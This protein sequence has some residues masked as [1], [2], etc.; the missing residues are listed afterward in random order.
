MLSLIIALPLNYDFFYY[1]FLGWFWETQTL[2]TNSQENKFSLNKTYY[3]TI[4]RVL[5]HFTHWCPPVQH[6]NLLTFSDLL[7]NTHPY[8][9]TLL[10]PVLK[11]IIQ[12]YIQLIVVNKVTTR[13]N[14]LLEPP[15]PNVSRSCWILSS[16]EEVVLVHGYLFILHNA[17]VFQG[18]AFF[19]VNYATTF[20]W[21]T[22]LTLLPP[23]FLALMCPDGLL[24]TFLNFIG[25]SGLWATLRQRS[26]SVYY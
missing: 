6:L 5:C 20:V 14:Y 26:C 8:W 19:I 21:A 22:V 2:I 25:P 12:I 24:K 10:Q 18:S 17:I 1:F 23:V 13:E 3:S 7:N 4:S 16:W 9:I 11:R 15:L